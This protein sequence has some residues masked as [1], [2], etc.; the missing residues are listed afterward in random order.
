MQFVISWRPQTSKFADTEDRSI[1]IYWRWRRLHMRKSFGRLVLGGV[2]IAGLALL[3]TDIHGSEPVKESAA[4]E[5]KAKQADTPKE[6]AEVAKQYRLRA[7]S[8]EAKAAKHEEAARKLRNNTN[9]MAHKWPA[10]VNNGWQRESQL[11]VQ[12]RRGAQE[13]YALAAKHVG[14]AVEGQHSVD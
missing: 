14:L 5:L 8:L 2:A 13:C 6:H 9:V 1:P 11:A 3:P 12:A 7:E 4:L 10:M